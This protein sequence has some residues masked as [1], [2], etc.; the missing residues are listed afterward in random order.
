MS[1][2]AASLGSDTAEDE[3]E[4]TGTGTG[5]IPLLETDTVLW[6]PPTLVAGRL[7]GPLALRV[8]GNEGNSSGRLTGA[9]GGNAISKVTLGA[10]E[11][12]GSDKGPPCP[13]STSCSQWA[14]ACLSSSTA[15]YRGYGSG[16]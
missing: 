3:G 8:T 9:W 15:M 2:A 4:V 5:S 1:A 6:N 14:H 10:D 11:I 7:D 16:G 13:G 12:T